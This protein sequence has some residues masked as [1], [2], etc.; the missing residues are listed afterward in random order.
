MRLCKL[1]RSTFSDNNV[2]ESQEC[3]LLGEKNINFQPKDKEIFR[4]KS[5]NAI[6]KEIPYLIRSYLEFYST[7]SIEQVTTRPTRVTD[8]TA[9]LVDHILTN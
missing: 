4:H 6:N 3:Y 2:F 5:A 9:A 7:R 8:Q 1:S